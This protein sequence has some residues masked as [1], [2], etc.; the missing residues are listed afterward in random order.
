MLHITKLLVVYHNL[1]LGCSFPEL[2]IVIDGPDVFADIEAIWVAHCY[3]RVGDF[4]SGQ[5]KSHDINTL[6]KVF[7]VVEGA[8]HL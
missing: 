2:E 3:S 1:G 8:V 6:R 4:G 5:G 7:P